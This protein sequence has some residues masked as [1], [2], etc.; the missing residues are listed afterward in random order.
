M[1]SNFIEISYATVQMYNHFCDYTNHPWPLSNDLKDFQRPWTF[2]AICRNVPEG[3]KILEIGGGNCMLADRLYK[4]GYEVWVVDPF[5]GSGGGPN[6]Y[7]ELI[8]QY[9]HLNFI[10]SEFQDSD[11]LNE[12]TYHACYSCSVVEHIQH[13]FYENIVRKIK[14]VLVSGGIS[15][16]AIDWV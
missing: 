3:G 6:N 10:R 9:P 16:H 12:G 13:S 2:N 11:D 5:D 4:A 1:F 15:A 8:C 14:E 7:E